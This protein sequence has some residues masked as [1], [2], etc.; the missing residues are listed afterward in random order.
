[1]LFA[2]HQSASR[3]SSIAGDGGTSTQSRYED[4]RTACIG[5]PPVVHE[6]LHS[7]HMRQFRPNSSQCHLSSVHGIAKIT[8]D[9]WRPDRCSVADSH[10]VGIW[11]TFEYVP[12]LKT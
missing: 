6:Q 12:T 4:I 5:V 3:L 2:Y 10:V 11:A 9:V 8:L 7:G 1:M